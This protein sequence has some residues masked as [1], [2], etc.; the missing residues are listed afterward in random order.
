MYFAID[1]PHGEANYF[2]QIDV[3]VCLK[4]ELFHWCHFEL[5]YAVTAR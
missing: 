1:S 3:K 5:N 2:I 4:P